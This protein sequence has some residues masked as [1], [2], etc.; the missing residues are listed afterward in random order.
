MREIEK[1][2]DDYMDDKKTP[3]KIRTTQKKCVS[4]QRRLVHPLAMPRPTE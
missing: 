1:V 2:P 4:L 3:I